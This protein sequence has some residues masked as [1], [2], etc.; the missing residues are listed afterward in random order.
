[1]LRIGT[2][3]NLWATWCA[4]C[5]AEL[6]HLTD[7]KSELNAAKIDVVALSVDMPTEIS[8]DS[9]I[10]TNAAAIL[11]DLSF[12]FSSGFADAD[13][14][15]HLQGA[16]DKMTSVNR[17]L[18]VP[19]SFLV[20]PRRQ[21]VAIYKGQLSVDQV[22]A[23]AK[24][25]DYPVQ[26]RIQN[27][28]PLGGSLVPSKTIRDTEISTEAGFQFYIGRELYAES[29]ELAAT[30]FA[31]ALRIQPEFIEPRIH[32]GIALNKMNRLE[33]AKQQLQF[34]LAQNPGEEEKGA[35]YYQLSEIALRQGRIDDAMPLLESTLQN[36]P[37]HPSAQNNLAFLLASKNAVDAPEFQR[38]LTMAERTVELTKSTHANFL[39]TLA[40]IYR[41]AGRFDEA[42]ETFEKALDVAREG[43][44]DDVVDKLQQKLDDTRQEANR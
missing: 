10:A 32:L 36:T 40:G 42:L 33:L 15:S 44:K 17:D 27:A 38:A 34:V 13:F 2:L 41:K 6:K 26:E 29:A 19:C 1:M 8:V 31:E 11:D 4:P 39:D 22:L 20:N 23:D 43:E 9:P 25:A 28:I 21:I 37:N 12:P 24:K 14:I 30:H 35:V 16:N 3:I 7:R 5:L 18:P